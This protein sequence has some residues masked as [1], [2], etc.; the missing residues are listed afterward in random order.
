MNDNEKNLTVNE[1]ND[2]NDNEKNLTVI[3]EN[4]EFDELD[5]MFLEFENSMSALQTQNLPMAE[6]AY[7]NVCNISQNISVDLQE[8]EL[9][10]VKL[11]V[12]HMCMVKDMLKVWFL[13]IEGRYRKAL[14]IV[15]SMEIIIDESES[16]FSQIEN[17][18]F[19]DG[20]F[21]LFNGSC[22]FFRCIINGVLL[23]LQCQIDVEDGKI[24]DAVSFSKQAI[25]CY[26]EINYQKW[27][28][29]NQIY[30]VF[31]QVLNNIADL[32]ERSIEKLEEKKKKIQY[33]SPTQRNVFI[34]HGHN[35][36]ILR[37]LKEMLTESFHLKPIILMNMP[38]KGGTLIEKFEN[39][40]K[41]TA[42]TFVIF[43][44]DDLI[45]KEGENYYQGR[46]NVM[47][48][49]GWFCG[50]FGRDRVRILKQEDTILP[51]DLNGI[52]TIDFNK[53]LEEVYRKI[54]NDLENAGILDV[55]D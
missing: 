8:N 54:K 35:E 26:R 14:E 2:E 12:N 28:S 19:L 51:S 50:R 47:F 23:V 21:D 46:P 24:V 34:V 20:M 1:D 4:D 25:K 37:E 3:K 41:D 45:N 49:L 33:I 40:A 31:T 13:M 38:D 11:L 43:T 27:P 48:E 29:N 7:F 5:E 16:L 15:R 53:K 36:S 44:K 42:F 10:V 9:A 18:D 52:L 6:Q 30:Y 39:Y 17:S 32:S 55:L 22:V